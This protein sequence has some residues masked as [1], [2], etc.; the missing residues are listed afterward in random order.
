MLFFWSSRRGAPRNDE[1]EIVG[2]A[3][4]LSR[5]AHHHLHGCGWM[6]G[7]L[8]PSLF[9]LRRTSRFAHPT[10]FSPQHLSQFRLRHLFQRRAR[11]VVDEMDLA[12]HLEVR[13][14][15]A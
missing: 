4:A 13:Q 9:E 5:R 3:K 10:K 1:A 15:S 7:T 6:V 12:R 2:W 14:R 8:P 11:H